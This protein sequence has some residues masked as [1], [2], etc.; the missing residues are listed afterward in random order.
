MSTFTKAVKKLAESFDAVK[1]M[2]WGEYNPNRRTAYPESKVRRGA[3]PIRESR[4]SIE[5]RYSIK[6]VLN[7]YAVDPACWEIHSLVTQALTMDDRAGYAAIEDICNRYWGNPATDRF[8]RQ[9]SVALRSGPMPPRDHFADEIPW[10]G[11]P[12]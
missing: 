10:P 5:S 4:D 11:E 2:G 1:D 12:R 8:V 7:K 9:L 6:L 3:S